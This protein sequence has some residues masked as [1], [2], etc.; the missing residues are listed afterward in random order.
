MMAGIFRIVAD[1]TT[2]YLKKLE[3]VIEL[4]KAHPTDF[5]PIKEDPLL[6]LDIL[7]G[8][9]EAT[10]QETF[11]TIARI[12]QF[13]HEYGIAAHVPVTPV[14]MAAQAADGLDRRE[15]IVPALRPAGLK[16]AA[17]TLRNKLYPPLK[18][19]VSKLKTG[20]FIGHWRSKIYLEVLEFLRARLKLP[21]EHIHYFE[22]GQ[23]ETPEVMP[24]LRKFLSVCGH[25]IIVASGEDGCGS[26]V[27]ARQNVVHEAGLF[28]GALGEGTVT[29]L[30]Q[31]GVTWISNDQGKVFLNFKDDHI[32]STFNDLR[33]R[34]DK[35][36]MLESGKV[37]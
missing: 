19:P 10:P 21:N 8:R 23:L 15:M 31:E 29:V 36:G 26:E 25:A 35:A 14:R 18:L 24:L 12:K 34:L 28:Q 22:I 13:T 6:L 7:S 5:I 20:I 16:D 30:L 32:A 11:K 37:K 3:T 33:D 27:R 1:L 9:I 17:A 2:D 4:I